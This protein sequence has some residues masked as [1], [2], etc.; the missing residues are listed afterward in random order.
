MKFCNVVLLKLKFRQFCETS[1]CFSGASNDYGINYV[2]YAKFV[3][4]IAEI[5][6]QS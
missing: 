1:E 3:Q 6:F 2:V 4:Y 5:T